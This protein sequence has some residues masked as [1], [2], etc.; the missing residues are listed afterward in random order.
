MSLKKKLPKLF[1]PKIVVYFGVNFPLLFSAKCP[2]L[3]IFF[4]S[5]CMSLIFAILEWSLKMESNA[6]IS[7]RRSRHLCFPHKMGLLLFGARS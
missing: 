2:D 3:F 1:A 6:N 7:C 5:K 4:L